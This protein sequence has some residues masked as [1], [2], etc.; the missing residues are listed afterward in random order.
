MPRRPCRCH[1][2]NG[3]TPHPHAGPIPITAAQA[4]TG[5]IT[6]T[7]RLFR[8]G[9]SEYLINGHTA[10]L[11]DIQDIFMGTRPGPGELRHHRA[12]P[13][14]PDPQLQAAGPPR[15]DRRGRRH[16]QVQDPQTAGGSQAG[17]RQAEPGAR[18][19]HSGRGHPAGEFAEAAGR[20]SAAATA[21]SRRRWM[22]ACAWRFPA[23]SAC[24]S[25][26]PPKPRST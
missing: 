7:R 16:H 12:G 3:H 18:V 21:S 17:E 20:Q 11:R 5:E 25:A 26:R 2:T 22:P 15:G 14:R 24:W 4:K 1:G 6:I 19:R 10:R 8:S 9:E 13:H 23:S